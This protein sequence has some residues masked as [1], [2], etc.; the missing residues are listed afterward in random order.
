MNNKD[1]SLES[2]TT[3]QLVNLLYESL[4]LETNSLINLV[5]VPMDSSVPVADVLSTKLEIKNRIKGYVSYLESLLEPDTDF[6]LNMHSLYGWYS[7]NLDL[8]IATSDEKIQ[9]DSAFN[10]ESQAKDFLQI[11]N[12]VPH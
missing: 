6:S 4:L 7:R 10:L 2:L 1:V 8:L 11:W 9:K 5:V 3:W 12:E